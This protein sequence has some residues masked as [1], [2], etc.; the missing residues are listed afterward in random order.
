MG[1]WLV[2]TPPNLHKKTFLFYLQ[3]HFSGKY[4]DYKFAKAIKI[5]TNNIESI[6]NVHNW[7]IKSNISRGWLCKMAKIKYGMLPMEILREV[8]FE[9][10]VQLMENNIEATCY[11]IAKDSGLSSAAA[12]RMFLTRHYSTNFKKLRLKLLNDELQIAWKW[13]NV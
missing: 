9:K 1:S 8:R 12:L 7:A 10:I 5:L 4:R 2:W 3:T 13:L 6:P 11:S